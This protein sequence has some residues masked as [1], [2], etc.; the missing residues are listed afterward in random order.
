MSDKENTYH[1]YWTS[2]DA[3]AGC[4][5]EAVDN[6]QDE[7]DAIWEAADGAYWVIMT[8]HAALTMQY[9]ENS[10]AY[11]EMTGETTVPGD[12]WSAVVCLLAAYAHVEDV[13]DRYAHLRKEK[14]EEEESAPSGLPIQG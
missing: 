7:S 4:A 2:V 6:G 1:D 13:R 14:K 9:S 10:D 12:H 8:Y 5:M 3:A 11:W